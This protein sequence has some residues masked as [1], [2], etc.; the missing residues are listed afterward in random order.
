MQLPIQQ[1]RVEWN[2]PL[3]KQAWQLYTETFPQNERRDL[4]THEFLMKNTP[5][6]HCEVLLQNKQ[7][8]GLLFWWKFEQLSFIEH[9]AILPTLRN[10]GIGQIVLQ[11]F[12]TATKTPIILEVEPAHNSAQKKRITF[13]ERLGFQL[14]KFPYLQPPYRKEDGFT[15]LHLMSYPQILSE[16]FFDDFKSEYLPQIYKNHFQAESL[17]N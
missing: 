17:K 1:I 13:Y 16:E 7:F 9:F 2:T 12:I 4:E 10:Q 14:N 5:T 15:P 6:F 11:N 3:F 8:S